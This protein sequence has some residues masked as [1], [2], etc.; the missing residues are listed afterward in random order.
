ML[1]LNL[2][3][4]TKVYEE[5]FEKG[6]IQAKLKMVPLLLELGLSIQ[7]IAERLKLDTDVVTE[8]ARN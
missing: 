6:E 4:N 2:I 3:R 8:A 1:N 7:Q 5:A